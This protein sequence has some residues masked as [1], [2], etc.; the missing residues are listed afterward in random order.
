MRIPSY[1]CK[2]FRNSEPESASYRFKQPAAIATR[3]LV[4]APEDELLADLLCLI[5]IAVSCERVIIL[6]KFK[7]A[8]GAAQRRNAIGYIFAEPKGREY[9]CTMVTAWQGP[10]KGK[11]VI[12]G[13]E[14]ECR[15]HYNKTE[16]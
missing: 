11:R 16:E 4:F 5:L 6:I 1:F 2:D 12:R 15:K 8:N 7:S 3:P 13:R 14:T 10:M 9:R